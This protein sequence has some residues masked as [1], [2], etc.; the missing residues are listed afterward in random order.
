M[1]GLF[2]L[3]GVCRVD[4]NGSIMM[5]DGVAYCPI[6]G[7]GLVSYYQVSKKLEGCYGRCEEGSGS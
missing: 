7:W 5:G 4:G 3:S 2:Y 1:A 6:D